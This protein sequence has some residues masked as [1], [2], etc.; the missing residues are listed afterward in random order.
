[1]KTIAICQ[2]G[3]WH[4][5][6]ASNGCKVCASP[7]TPIATPRGDRFISQLGVGDLVY[8]VEDEAIVP[9]PILRVNRTPVLAH[10]V[11]RVELAGGRTLEISAGHPTADGRTFGDLRAGG[12]LDGVSIEAIARVPYR[13]PYTYDIL[14]ASRSGH[15][16][17]AGLLI[18]STL[19]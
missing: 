5:T 19:R 6:T 3:L 11:V 17:A 9:V 13:H 16:F 10:E 7:D 8:T 2:G 12:K 1:M 14:P 18:G 15:Y 4:W